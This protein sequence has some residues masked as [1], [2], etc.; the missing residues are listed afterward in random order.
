MVTRLEDTNSCCCSLDVVIPVF[1]ESDVLPQFLERLESA[2]DERA[3]D[4]LQLGRVRFLLFDDGSTD[5]SVQ[6]IAEWIESGADA[7]LF[8]FTRNFGH[9]AAVIAG[10]DHADAD[11][12]AV[13]DADLQDPPEVLVSMIER[14]RA[15]ADVVFGRRRRRREGLVRRLG[16]W[17]GYRLIAGLSDVA[18]PLDAGDFCVMDRRVVE[19]LR[20]LP[21]HLRFTRG[22][23]AWVGF[24][25]EELAYDRPER[26]AGE[27][28]YTLGKLY[29][30]AT[31]GV[32]SMSTRPLKVAQLI[33]FLYA[34]LTL[35]L[36]VTLV[37]RLSSADSSTLEIWFLALGILVASGSMVQA[38]YLYVLGG[39]IGRTYLEVKAR[40]A[41]LIS[42]AI[43]GGASD[44]PQ[45]GRRAIPRSDVP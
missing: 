34:V 33:S 6:V 1:N 23:R 42:E 18:M 40:P 5:D 15:G 30:L 13:M 9:Q 43:G 36:V 41:Y 45:R 11:A 37:L 20:K 38:A 26:A 39:Y 35:I 25:Q 7:T 12:V 10:I 14:W 3:L 8:R 19:A 24:A 4:R 44:L 27:T 21:E 16:Y 2:F 31:D 22:L 29:K 28:K 17:L 32:A